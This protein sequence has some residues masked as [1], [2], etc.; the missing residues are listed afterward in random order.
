MKQHRFKS[1]V[2][3]FLVLVL[4]I[5]LLPMGEKAVEVKADN[6]YSQPLRVHSW[7]ELQAALGQNGATIVLENNIFAESNETGLVATGSAIKMDLKGYA[8]D[9]KLTTASGG[10][11][12]FNV[13]TGAGFVLK[14]ASGASVT[15]VNNAARKGLITGGGNTGNGGG[16]IVEDGGFISLQNCSISGNNAAYGGGIYAAGGTVKLK[17]CDIYGNNSSGKGSAVFVSGAVLSLDGTIYTG[18]NDI[19]SEG[20]GIDV[21]DTIDSEGSNI[22]IV[23]E[24]GADI[25]V[26]NSLTEEKAQRFYAKDEAGNPLVFD[27]Y[28][29]RFYRE[30]VVTAPGVVGGL[31]YD[32]S[33][34]NL[35]NAGSASGG[36]IWYQIS[37]TENAPE[38]FSEGSTVTNAW[39]NKAT[40]IVGTDAGTYKI[41][42]AVVGQGECSNVKPAYVTVTIGKTDF[43]VATCSAVS[44]EALTVQHKTVRLPAL[45]SGMSYGTPEVVNSIGDTTFID[46][47]TLSKVDYHD[48]YET[49]KALEFYVTKRNFNTRARI[50][51]HVKGGTNY[52]DTE[53]TVDVVANIKKTQTPYFNPKEYTVAYGDNNNEFTTELIKSQGQVIYS[54]SDRSVAV[55]EDVNASNGK[56]IIKGVGT[57][58]ITATA[59]GDDNYS[60]ASDSYTLTVTKGTPAF[61]RPEGEGDLTFRPASGGAVGIGQSLLKAAA[62]VTGGAIY[63]AVTSAD[64]ATPPAIDFEH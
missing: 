20:L 37:N 58:T 59:Q 25:F 35:I 24:P 31:V 60:D 51:I 2:A 5:G 52:N 22:N 29:K 64:V 56:L 1:F 13:A 28:R 19:V 62:S 30:A 34:K 54:S 43:A 14:V 15:I 6:A 26:Y 7:A 41:W 57:T 17:N 46:S 23:C 45:A 40:R 16:I 49:G 27:P 48:G 8:I 63:Y 50:K 47:N 9:R 4:T 53:V 3:L 18:D 11:I 32:G 10:G 42:Y 33:A 39:T 61:A 44:V 55:V 36:A 38:L 12:D 21:N